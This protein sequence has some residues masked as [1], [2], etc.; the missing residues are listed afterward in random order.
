[1]ETLKTLWLKLVTGLAFYPTYE[2]WKHVSIAFICA[3]KVT[4]YPTYEEWKRS[5]EMSCVSGC[6]SFLSYL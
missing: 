5:C 4:F 3:G 1:M 2:E 6:N